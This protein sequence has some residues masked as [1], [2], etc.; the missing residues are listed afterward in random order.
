MIF[1]LEKKTHF[2]NKYVLIALA[3]NLRV[4]EKR[5]KIKVIV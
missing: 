5:I 1:Y 2:L 4:V 3:E